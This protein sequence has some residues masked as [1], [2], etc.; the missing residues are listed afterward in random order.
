[1]N[2]LIAAEGLGDTRGSMGSGRGGRGG[3]ETRA[4]LVE[5]LIMQKFREGLGAN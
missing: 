2:A 4:K 3:A 1:M 5:H